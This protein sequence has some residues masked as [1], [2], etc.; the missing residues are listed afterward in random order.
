MVTL[1]VALI[2]IGFSGWM[3][4]RRLCKAIDGGGAQEEPIVE[5]NMVGVATEAFSASQQHYNHNSNYGNDS[6]SPSGAHI[7][8]MNSYG[9]GGNIPPV[10]PLPGNIPSFMG[11]HASQ[12]DMPLPPVPAAYP[13][14]PPA[15]GVPPAPL[16]PMSDLLMPA[17]VH[18][19][20]N[21]S[22]VY[23]VRRSVDA[24]SDNN[25][26]AAQLYSFETIKVNPDRSQAQNLNQ[27]TSA[28]QY[29]TP[30]E[31]AAAST[32]QAHRPALISAELLPHDSASDI[33]LS[34]FP[35][36]PNNDAYV[37]NWVNTA[38]T[39][40]RDSYY[41][42]SNEAQK[43]PAAS[44]IDDLLESMLETYAESS[45]QTTNPNA[46]HQQQQPPPLPPSIPLPSLMPG[47]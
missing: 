21:E 37:E 7:I 16:L 13:P 32:A 20:S 25:D 1:V 9:S 3:S 41:G 4:Y 42:Q 44:S 18:Y 14:A 27:S 10:P 24:E 43:V 47:N 30:N 6:G 29:P 22:H 17:P 8:D 23:G 35:S 33:R 31:N 45:L 38:A 19:H 46:H 26:E 5:V 36:K 34:A 39:D 15:A 12:M 2:S 11:S 28:M 40:S